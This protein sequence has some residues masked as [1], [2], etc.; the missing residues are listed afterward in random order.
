MTQTFT[1][2]TK[3]NVPPMIEDEDGHLWGF[4][5]S[6]GHGAFHVDGV[7]GNFDELFG[8]PFASVEEAFDAVR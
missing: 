7:H 2:T 6:D 1:L 8:V 4:I 5:V 3:P